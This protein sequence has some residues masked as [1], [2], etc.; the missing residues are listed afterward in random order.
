[1]LSN[2]VTVGTSTSMGGKVLT[3]SAGVKINN[4]D[5]SV[6][7]DQASCACG[8]KNCR[9][10]GPILQGSPRNI[11]IGG[12]LI[13]MKDDPVDT[14]CG[15]CFLLSSGDSVSLGAQT[16]GSI[17]MGSG[18]NIGQGVNINMGA[19]VT[20][21]GSS[22]SVASSQSLATSIEGRQTTATASG[23]LDSKAEG[24]T[25]ISVVNNSG[26]RRES[27][28]HNTPAIFV[29]VENPNANNSK[30]NVEIS[31]FNPI[32]DGSIYNDIGEKYGLD[33]D[34]LKAIAYMENTHG[35]Y[36][37]FPLAH[38]I[39]TLITGSPPSYRPMNIQYDTWKPLADQLGFNEWQV[40]YRVACNVEL[41]ALLLKRIT[42]RIQ[43]PSLAKVASIYNFLGK[44]KVSD[45]GARVQEI[46]DKKLWEE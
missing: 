27:I 15:N 18:V 45:Y 8:A 16:S 29:I 1:M 3:G 14:G 35:W 6:V 39:K 37:G 20:F 33:P 30:P 28:L 40:Q 42:V 41:A 12:K 11:K 7:G 34:W 4:L 38:E 10:V 46:Y 9:G 19:G 23:E 43:Q 31:A 2:A 13:A 22:I 32:S 44:E 17:N 21:G 36:D 26:D 5:V 25:S 24:Q